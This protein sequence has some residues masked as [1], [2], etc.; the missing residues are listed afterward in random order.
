[1]ASPS[2]A[3][4][5]KGTLHGVGPDAFFSLAAPSGSWA[6]GD[7]ELW[8]CLETT[9]LANT[10]TWWCGGRADVEA[11]AL[12]AKRLTEA[13]AQQ[14]LK[15]GFA[16]APTFAIAWW[17][18]ESGNL[19]AVALVE[20]AGNQE[21]C[22]VRA[23]DTRTPALSSRLTR[24]DGLASVRDHGRQCVDAL[25]HLGVGRPDLR[26]DLFGLACTMATASYLAAQPAPV[27]AALRAWEMG[28]A[29]PGMAPA[30]VSLRP[31]L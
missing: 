10:V 15:T 7:K 16:K 19:A 18:S 31:R 23:L 27:K 13:T 12:A 8:T 2:S 3:P 6:W 28:A 5:W 22:S 14:L 11:R 24:F 26:D 9:D 25:L 30:R 1:M 20:F 4:V 29:W 21:L 17:E